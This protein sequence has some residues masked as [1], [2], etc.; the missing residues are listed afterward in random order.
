M[1]RRCMLWPFSIL[2][3][4]GV[5]MRNKLYDWGMLKST[6]FGIPIISVG[7]LSTGGTGKT[8]QIEY[9][10]RLLS[11]YKVATLSRGYGGSQKTY[12][13][14]QLKDGAALVGDEPL[15]LK[16]KFPNIDVA[17]A[18]NRVEGI[19]NLLRDAN[20]EVILLD[21]AFQH[22]RLKPGFSILL[23]P[24]DAPF[25][26]DS[27]LPGGNLREWVMGKERADVIV[28][29]KCPST[30]AAEKKATYISSINP[31]E[32]QLVLFSYLSYSGLIAVNQTAN[33]FRIYEETN[34]LLLSGIANPHHFKNYCSTHFK[35]AGHLVY[36][37]HHE[38]TDIDLARIKQK[39]DI[40]ANPNK[41]IVTTEKD[42]M[43]LKGSKSAEPLKDLPIYYLP[44]ATSFFDEDEKKLNS[45]ILNYVAG[46][47]RNH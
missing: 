34:L 35:V 7:N 25:F 41:A 21:D 6:S 13:L 24:Y 32:N 26:K 47:K 3:G 4:L 33:N 27:I 28:V 46:N 8:P 40:I 29:S 18:P 38:Y 12:H 22:R 1:L 2:Y 23:T 36:G 17:I 19:N 42:A 5:F 9:L 11:K 39:F 15:Q 44:V 16:T 10:I 20:P 30:L 14:V 37:D 45:L 43:R 31:L